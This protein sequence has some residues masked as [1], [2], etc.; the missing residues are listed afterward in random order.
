MNKPGF[1]V[2]WLILASTAFAD[3]APNIVL[4]LTD[5]QG[6][7][8]TSVP[9]DQKLPGS[10]SDL[11]QTPSLEK[12]AEQ[13]MRFSNGYSPAPNC[14]P[15]RMSIQTGKTAP[16]L[17][18]T[19]IIDVV[20]RDGVAGLFYNRFYVNKPLKVHLPISDLP[21]D[22]IT[23]GEL[24]KS[25]NAAYKTAHFG[26]WHMGGGSPDR[27][28]YDAHSGLT[29]N[30][31]GSVGEPD[32]KRT[33]EVTTQATEFIAEHAGKSP[34]FVQVSYYAVHTPI[35]A[36]GE[37]ID[38]YASKTSRQHMNYLYAAMT[39]ELDQGLGRILD[40][41]EQSEIGD[42]TYVI[43]TSDNGGEITGGVVTNNVPLARGKTSV[44]EG[45]VRVPLIIRGPGIKPG[46]QCDVPAIG[47]DLLPTIAAWVGAT[48]KLP[49]DLD[50]GSL[51][52]VLA[53]EGKGEV[54]R[55]TD[56]LIWY[57]GAYRNNKHVAPQAAIRRGPHKL[58]WELDTDRASLF[59]LSVDISE[60][61]DLTRFRPEVASGLRQE[62]EEYFAQVGTKLPTINPDY[63]PAKDPGLAPRGAGRGG[64]RGAGQFQRGGAQG[65]RGQQGQRR[66]G[67]NAGGGR[68][69]PQLDQ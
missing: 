27:H 6:W 26:K 50:G 58:I 47:Y 63:D 54:A 1:C 8:G 52:R 12:L 32:P 37:T 36:K 31:Q 40:Q 67:A 25:H 53:S 22:E 49:E 59:D 38:S 44:W 56:S 57:Y 28:G 65:A 14:S 18:A 16:R 4:I 2:A 3:D 21:D 19:D 15:T 39:D 10:A 30:R 7:T 17:G 9:M 5:D 60:T 62:L 69:R 43:Y 68:R 29:S 33:G 23:I 20:P 34:F 64:M 42:N 13:G 35:R 24:L 51:D 11:Y 48:D 41:I 46:S 61:T 45:G 66:G 55:G